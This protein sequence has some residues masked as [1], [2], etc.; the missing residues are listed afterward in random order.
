MDTDNFDRKHFLGS[1]IRCVFHVSSKEYQKRVWIE[2][3]GPECDDFE[4]TANFIIGDG[5]I[6]LKNYRDFGINDDQFFLLNGFYSEF[7]FF[8]DEHFFAQ[9]FI[10]TPEWTKITEMAKEVLKAFHW[11]T[12]DQEF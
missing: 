9:E 5:E 3:R 1:F 6:I 11:K 2:G 10:D 7:N 12:P 8:S 4:D